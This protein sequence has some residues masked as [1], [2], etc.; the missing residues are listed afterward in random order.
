MDR[1][2]SGWIGM[3]RDGSGWIGMDWDGLGWIG[4]D[5]TGLHLRISVGLV[6]WD[7]GLGR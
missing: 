5:Q 2:G 1:D 7:L 6:D 3:D 4:L